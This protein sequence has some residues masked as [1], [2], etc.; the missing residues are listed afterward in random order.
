MKQLPYSLRRDVVAMGAVVG[1][2]VFGGLMGFAGAAGLG[3]E[4]GQRYDYEAVLDG[5]ARAQREDCK[6]WAYVTQEEFRAL[7]K[8]Y[9]AKGYDEWVKRL[10]LVREGMSYEEVERVLKPKKISQWTTYGAG[11]S[12]SIELDDAYVV[13]GMFHYKEGLQGKLT[14]PVAITYGV[15]LGGGKKEN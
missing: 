4:A 15:K 11:T 1:F 9:D 2:V 7:Q 6:Y 5:D 8:K 12:T 14:G 10:A 3:V 13:Y